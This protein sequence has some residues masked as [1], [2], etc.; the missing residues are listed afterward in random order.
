MSIYDPTTVLGVFAKDYNIS[1]SSRLICKMMES[2]LS[3]L[4]PSSNSC[5][6]G[7]TKGGINWHEMRLT[8]S[9]R[10]LPYSF[11]LFIGYWHKRKISEP[12]HFLHRLQNN[13][14]EIR[15]A[16]FLSSQAVGRKIL[17]IVTSLNYF[18]TFSRLCKQMSLTP[19]SSEYYLVPSEGEVGCRPSS[20]V[21]SEDCIRNCRIWEDEY[22]P[23]PFLCKPLKNA[24]TILSIGAIRCLL[25]LL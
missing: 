24:F 18:V 4:K 15:T 7:P 21:S 10:C 3:S 16:E 6:Y 5:K 1:F 20:K 19:S 13:S 12:F 11:V 23:P 14:T 17:S 8:R 22:I 2:T 9:V 25:G